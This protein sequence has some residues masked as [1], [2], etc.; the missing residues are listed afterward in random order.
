MN[1]LVTIQNVKG[2]LDQNGTAWLNLEDVARGLGFTTIATS[3]N[4]CVRWQRVYEYLQDLNFHYEGMVKDVFIPENIFYRLAMKA[5]NET[6]EKFQALIADEILP[7][8][9]KT[10]S[11]SVQPKSIEDLIIMQAQSMKDIRTRL[12][13]S[14]NQITAIKDTLLSSEQNWREWVNE[15]L[16]QVAFAKGGTDSF[17]DARRESYAELESRSFC[18]LKIRLKKMTE[19][20]ALAGET[21]T[22][23]NSKNLL[24]VIETD[25]RIKE[26]YTSIL[27]EMVV[28][29]I[30]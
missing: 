7:A 30:A 13:K 29:Y 25:Q 23:I 8:I 17:R 15:K 27:K 10:G 26:I 19:R 14:E 16:N 6:A 9:R 4:E 1:D 11:Y 3:G 18:D 28:K 20:M 21:K 2:Y 12:E 24:D 5:K 22:A